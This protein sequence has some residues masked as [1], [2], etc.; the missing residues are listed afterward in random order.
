MGTKIY[1][2]IPNIKF[3]HQCCFTALCIKYNAVVSV[4]INDNIISMYLILV[5]IY[6]IKT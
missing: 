1:I 6:I 4:T 5:V 2:K 3:L